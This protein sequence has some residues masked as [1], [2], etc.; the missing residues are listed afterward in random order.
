MTVT[1]SAFA[2]QQGITANQKAPAV[3]AGFSGGLTQ[4]LSQTAPHKASTRPH[5]LSSSET[6]TSATRAAIEQSKIIHTKNPYN[7]KGIPDEIY[8]LFLD[9]GYSEV[10]QDSNAA[11]AASIFIGYVI[12]EA[13]YVDQGVDPSEF[14]P[15]KP[16]SNPEKIDW[17]KIFRE[18]A[19]EALDSLSEERTKEAEGWYREEISN[20]K[21]DL[22]YLSKER[23][24]AWVKYQVE[25]YKERGSIMAEIGNY[26]AENYKK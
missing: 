12:W 14:D 17:V 21:H 22:Y 11:T 25:L 23:K 3:Q 8:Q 20:P 1:A 18:A 5:T 19:A 15:T 9:G 13:M 26:M 10:H 4:A 24:E 16:I 2:Q 7:E 6:A